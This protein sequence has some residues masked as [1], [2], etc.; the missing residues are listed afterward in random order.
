MKF[1]TLAIV[2]VVA[3]LI[4]S[5]LATANARGDEASDAKAALALALQQK[6]KPVPPPAPVPVKPVVAPVAPVATTGVC[7]DGSCGLST[8]EA[9]AALQPRLRALRHHGLRRGG[10]CRSGSC[11]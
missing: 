10:R 5:M 2:T 11:G 8:S 1:S 3:L 9:P 6:K 4:A 7:V